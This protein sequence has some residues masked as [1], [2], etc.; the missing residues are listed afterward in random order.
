MEFCGN[1]ESCFYSNSCESKILQ[2]LRTFAIFEL[3]L[4]WVDNI[5]TRRCFHIVSTLKIASKS[6]QTSDLRHSSTCCREKLECRMPREDACNQSFRHWL[7][8]K[9]FWN[10]IS[11]VKVWAHFCSSLK[12]ITK[13]F[14]TQMTPRM[15]HHTRNHVTFFS[16]L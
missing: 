13:I 14:S 6:S 3:T 4:E 12:I 11:N 5:A 2:Y 9:S 16:S 10:V 1:F 15:S 8:E 7:P